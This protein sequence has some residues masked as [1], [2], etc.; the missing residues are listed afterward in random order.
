MGKK[1]TLKPRDDDKAV[2]A[3]LVNDY[4]EARD[5]VQRLDVDAFVLEVSSA[6]V[7][8][9]AEIYT[10]HEGEPIHYVQIEMATAGLPYGSPLATEL[11]RFCEE[12]A[13]RFDLVVLVGKDT[14]PVAAFFDE[15]GF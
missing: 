12:L 3:Q 8:S 2:D 15:G 1:I 4:L 11:R 6:D 10:G 7:A 14:K 5:D 13:S 9:Q